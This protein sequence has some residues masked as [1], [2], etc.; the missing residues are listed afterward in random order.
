MYDYMKPME[1]PL[2]HKSTGGAIIINTSIF[3]MDIL[4]LVLCTIKIYIY[5]IIVYNPLNL[6]K[7]KILMTKSTQRM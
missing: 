6:I 1:V 3:Y 7:H 4:Y 5:S 2:I